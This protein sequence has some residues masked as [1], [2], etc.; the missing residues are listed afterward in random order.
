MVKLLSPHTTTMSHSQSCT[1][2]TLH[3]MLH[4]LHVSILKFL[5]FLSTSISE[6]QHATFRNPFIPTATCTNNHNVISFQQIK[7]VGTNKILVCYENQA[8]GLFL[9][10]QTEPTRGL[11]SAKLLS[12]III[13]HKLFFSLLQARCTSC[14]STGYSK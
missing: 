5:L 12:Q 4:C 3:D 10:L 6:L 9:Q 8:P 2:H 14:H 1:L 7:L 13:T 11:R